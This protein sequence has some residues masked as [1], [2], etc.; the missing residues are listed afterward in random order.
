LFSKTEISPSVVEKLKESFEP[1]AQV[2]YLRILEGAV[3][4]SYGQTSPP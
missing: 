4:R 1:V 2:V 3:A